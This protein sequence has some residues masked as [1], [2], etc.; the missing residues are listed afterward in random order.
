MGPLRRARSTQ[1]LS[2]MRGSRQRILSSQIHHIFGLPP[3]F[4]SHHKVLQ[5]ITHHHTQVSK[6]KRR[7]IKS[8]MRW[9]QKK[10]KGW[11]SLR[12]YLHDHASSP[13]LLYSPHVATFSMIQH[14]FEALGTCL[15][16]PDPESHA[17]HLT[18]YSTTDLSH[19]GM[20]TVSFGSF[21]RR[22]VTFFSYHGRVALY[23]PAHHQLSWHRQSI[24]SS[25]LQRYAHQVQAVVCLF[26]ARESSSLPPA[27]RLFWHS[28]SCAAALRQESTAGPYLEQMTCAFIEKMMHAYPEQWP[29][30]EELPPDL[31]SSLSKA[32]AYP[33]E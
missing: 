9:W 30:H 11:E 19:R 23:A 8:P 3:H 17:P 14:L 24:L 10:V 5:Q 12:T 29:W 32:Q 18:Q 15:P 1:I 22:L 28:T 31:L 27:Y 7:C 6:H 21:P 16:E 13:L 2:L 33:R 26:L 25:E 20:P 4:P